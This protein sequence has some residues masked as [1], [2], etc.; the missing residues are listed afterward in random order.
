[1]ISI[2]FDDPV[3]REFN[4][5]GGVIINNRTNSSSE[6][7]NR[8]CGTNRL[9]ADEACLQSIATMHRYVAIINTY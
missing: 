5:L 4:F 8:L 2:F 9:C 1:M 6:A 7:T 3:K